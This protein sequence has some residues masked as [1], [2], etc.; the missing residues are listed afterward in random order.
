MYGKDRKSKTLL[1]QSKNNVYTKVRRNFPNNKECGCSCD[2]T[3][4]ISKNMA[5]CGHT[6]ALEC[7][8]VD[9]PANEEVKVVNLKN[10]GARMSKQQLVNL[11]L[12]ASQRQ[13]TTAT[14]VSHILR[15]RGV[16]PTEQAEKTIDRRAVK[17]SIKKL[18]LTIVRAFLEQKKLDRKIVTK[19]VIKATDE[20]N[21][22]VGQSRTAVFT[23]SKLML[24]LMHSCFIRDLQLEK[25]IW[26]VDLVALFLNERLFGRNEF[27]SVISKILLGNH[28]RRQIV[29]ALVH[30]MQE[31][32]GA[33]KWCL[34]LLRFSD[35]ADH[36]EYF[37][38]LALGKVAVEDLLASETRNFI[39]EMESKTLKCIYERFIIANFDCDFNTVPASA[40]FE[41]P[42]GSVANRLMQYLL[43]KNTLADVDEM[44]RVLPMLPD[45][46]DIF[47]RVLSRTAPNITAESAARIKLPKLFLKKYLKVF[48]AN[49]TFSY[50][51]FLIIANSLFTNFSE[52]D[53]SLSFTQTSSFKKVAEYFCSRFIYEPLSQERYTLWY[54]PII[55]ALCIQQQKFEKRNIIEAVVNHPVYHL[56]S[57][58]C[59]RRCFKPQR[60]SKDSRISCFNVC[61]RLLET[62]GQNV[63]RNVEKKNICAFFRDFKERENY[64]FWN[65]HNNLFSNTS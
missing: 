5:V 31:A 44:F 15:R 9:E 58:W 26:I 39:Q 28:T 24:L 18:L 59:C 49:S 48:L 21:E 32:F 29:E 64:D 40:Y 6:L 10:A 46:I 52:N 60:G 7:R 37:L 33:Q 8:D 25:E 16:R 51:F 2:A 56:G 17:D 61:S 11:I 14:L 30:P 23:I 19:R 53:V 36:D 22:Q 54:E 12:E 62:F 43:D 57:A 47:T 65:D 63:F 41:E 35:A 45:E 13:N 4:V 3:V 50:N 38:L 1:L 27:S 34:F 42:S 55:W 20:L